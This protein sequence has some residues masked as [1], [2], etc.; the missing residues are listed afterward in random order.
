MSFLKE[1][2]EDVE[3]NIKYNIVEISDIYGPTIVDPNIDM[4][5]VSE[6]TKKG[7]EKVNEERG[8]RDF[9]FLDI[10]V[11]RL[12]EDASIEEHEETKI[13]SSNHRIRL[14]GTRLKK[15]VR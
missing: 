1:F 14:L 12:A 6:E 15:P 11:V 5:V 10:Y 13:S 7:G 3:P 2:T 9:K 8:K 4:I